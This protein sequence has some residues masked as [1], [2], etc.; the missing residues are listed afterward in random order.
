MAIDKVCSA[1]LE[2]NELGAVND[3]QISLNL[4]PLT[5]SSNIFVFKKL[6]INN[7]TI[8][9]QTLKRVKRRNNYMVTFTDTRFPGKI[10]YG[11]VQKYVMLPQHDLVLAVANQVIPDDSPIFC[12]Q[13]YPSELRYL[14]RVLTSDFIRV[15]LTSEKIALQ[16]HHI[17]DKCILTMSENIFLLSLLVNE[18]ETCE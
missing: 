5:S 9:S 18:N 8:F 12:A 2:E 4:D 16:V 13:K 15:T 17:Q 11:G 7:C 14:S 10:L 1:C 6:R 3:L